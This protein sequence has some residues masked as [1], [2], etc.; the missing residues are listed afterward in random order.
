MNNIYDDDKFFNSYKAM[1]RSKGGLESAG[2]WHELKTMFPD[3]NGKTVLDLGCG[4]GWHSTYAHKMGAIKIHAIDIS[5]KM[6]EEAMKIN[7]APNIEYEECNIKDYSYPADSYD[8]VISNLVLHYI[9]D[10][11]DIYRKVY[12]TLKKGG[13]FLFNIEHPVF[14]SGIKED[15]I[16]GEDGKPK[17]WALDNYYY[18]GKRECIFLGNKVIKEHHTLTQILNSLLT[19]GFRIDKIKEPTPPDSMMN[20]RGMKDEMRRPMML[21]VKAIKES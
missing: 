3:V 4:Y 13:V 21:L 8:L 20:I 11:D 6:L 7:N 2:E 17:Y 1:P 10:L 14:T 15:W 16:Y 18:P 12:K 19:V 5:K 9:D